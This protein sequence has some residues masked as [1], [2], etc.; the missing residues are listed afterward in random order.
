MSSA[1]IQLL[2]GSLRSFKE[3]MGGSGLSESELTGAS[4]CKGGEVW[5]SGFEMF[6]I[7]S[8]GWGV[9]CSECDGGFEGAV[10]I[11]W[12][13]SIEDLIGRMNCL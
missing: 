12:K 13:T 11:S 3:G 8:W 5:S 10:G 6:W 2:S 9:G 4:A 7:S 1:L